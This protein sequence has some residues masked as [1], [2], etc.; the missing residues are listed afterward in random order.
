M[1]TPV[2][3]QV[4]GS[5]LQEARDCLPAMRASLEALSR[6]PGDQGALA[7]LH[8]LA[9]NMGGAS[10]V[11]GL[12]EI[13][14][15]AEGLEQLLDQVAAGGL[16][17]DAELASLVG[18]GLDQME[19]ALGGLAGPAPPSG[20]PAGDRGAGDRDLASDL[21]PGFVLEAEEHLQLIGARLAEVDRSADRQATLREVRRSVHTIKGAAAMVGLSPIRQL[22]HRMEDLLD[23]LWDGPLEFTPDCGRLLGA[24][25]DA[26]GDL[27]QARGATDGLEGRLAALYADYEAMLAPAEASAGAPETLAE[28]A[29][30]GAAADL[31]PETAGFVRVPIER[32]DELM[33]LVGELFV[34]RS[35]LEQ[36][37]GEVA[38]ELTELSL[39]QQ[40]L[41]RLSSQLESQ[42]AAFLPAAAVTH[43]EAEAEGPEFDALEFDRYSQIHLLSRDL[44]ETGADVLSAAERLL[45]LRGG[46]ESFLRRHSHLMS[47]VKD[48]LTRVRMVPLETLAARLHRAVRVTASMCGKQVEFTI[49]GAATGFDQAVLARL[50]GPLEH[51]LR[52][53]VD[54]GIEDAA[55]RAAAG[56]PGRGSITLAAWQ[57]GTDLV[58]RLADDGRGLDDDKLRGEAVRQGYLSPEEAAAATSEQLHRFVFESGFSTAAEISEISGRGVGLDVV[59]A[60][61]ESLRGAVSVESTPGRGVAFVLRLPMRLAIA[62]VLLVK[63]QNQRYALPL[64]AITEVGRI[65]AR[66]WERHG[67]ELR[68]RMAGRTVQAFD[69]AV[70][71]GAR[72]AYEPRQGR[73]PVVAMRLGDAEFALVV[74]DI[75]EAREVAVKPLAGVLARVHAVAG[76]TILGDGSVV[77]ILNPAQLGSGV[78]ARVSP[79]RTSQVR[80]AAARRALDVLIVDDSLSV[81]RVVANLVRTSGWNPLQAKDGVEALDLL[82]RLQRAP[83]VILLDIEMPRMDGFELTARLRANDHFRH[84]PIVMLTSRAGEK[85]RSKAFSLGVT[86]YL[87]KPYQDEVLL[88]TIRRLVAHSKVA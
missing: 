60:T 80:P 31:A 34:E 44:G 68:V 85:H 15:L 58:L 75:L 63:A 26:L 5:F 50:A 33:R 86:D 19:G 82:S 4:L 53:A 57:E 27:V 25:Y 54:H 59:R 10:R 42:E 2:A 39:S 77:L 52:N 66:N 79:L 21:I 38:V 84:L 48:R 11:I 36:Q 3:S 78:P 74:D 32:L 47:E 6:E 62:K 1:D 22:A 49:E 87:V 88:G 29:A 70:Q 72:D 28:T 43:S 40:R 17:F 51:L 61:V 8:R 71:L 69:L 18:Q 67:N 55:A 46:L 20:E 56:K 14:E 30:P 73:L 65:E 76:A 7:E 9:H 13:G 64:D 41:R 12:P 35:I 81:R 37:L 24:T 23:Q 16:P 83:D 45:D